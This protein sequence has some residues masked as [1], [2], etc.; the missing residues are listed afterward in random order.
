LI[1][2][3]LNAEGC[4]E[5]KQFVKE[6]IKAVLAEKKILLSTAFTALLQTLKDDP[7][8]VNLIYSI[9]SANDGEQHKDNNA[10]KY[11]EVNKHKILNLAEKN[12]ENLVE[13]L[14]N[15]AI[16]TATTS[17]NPTLL[18]PLPSSVFQN[19]TNQNSTYRKEDPQ[20]FHDSKG[21]IAE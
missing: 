17:S 8:L 4:S 12:Y 11:I 14:T 2:N 1:A 3:I 21:D 7:E 19:L 15:D 9:S 16:A 5:L 13:A 6:N 20:S 10:I 18:L